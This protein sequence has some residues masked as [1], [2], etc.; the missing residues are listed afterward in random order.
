[1]TKKIMDDWLKNVSKQELMKIIE[2]E[3]AEKFEWR[4]KYESTLEARIE[5][6]DR[7]KMNTPC[8]CC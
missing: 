4:N 8:D 5:R 6:L 2:K 3:R 7:D 1:M